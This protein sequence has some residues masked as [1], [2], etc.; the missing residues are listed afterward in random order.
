[1]TSTNRCSPSVCVCVCGCVLGVAR[2]TDVTHT[3]THTSVPALLP[4]QRCWYFIKIN[5]SEPNISAHP[6]VTVGTWLMYKPII[7][8]I[9]N[10]FSFRYVTLQIW[11]YSGMFG[12]VPNERCRTHEHKAHLSYSSVRKPLSVH[13]R[14]AFRI[15]TWSLSS[16]LCF[17]VRNSRHSLFFCWWLSNSVTLL[18]APPSGLGVNCLNPS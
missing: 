18:R 4:W 1:M 15:S 9:N 8:I 16:G 14:D 3:H 7:C 13:V 11:K 5:Y 6:C 2:Y 12:F 17:Q 10:S